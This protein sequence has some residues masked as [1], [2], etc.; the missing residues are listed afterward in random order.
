MKN[1]DKDLHLTKKIL[2]YSFLLLISMSLFF[3]S[4]KDLLEEAPKAVAEEL[5]YNTIEEI[6]SS[7]NAIYPPLSWW[8][9]EQTLI[10]DAHTDWGYGR[11]SRADYNSFQGFNSSNI[12]QA[13]NRWNSYYLG[14]RN[15]NILIK[16]ASEAT[17]LDQNDVKKYIGE[18]KFIRALAYFDLVRNWGSVPLRT[19]D[20]MTEQDIEKSPVETIYDFIITDLLAGEADLPETQV[21]IGRPTKYSAKTLLADVYLTLGNFAEARDKANEVIQSGKYSL[22]PVESKEDFQ[23]NLFGPDIITTP[24][25]IFYFKYKRESDYGNWIL[26]VLNHPST[27][28]FN[29][30]GAFAH[31]S[32]SKLP[33]HQNWEDGDIRKELWDQVDFG[34]GPTTLVSN[35]Y[36]DTEAVERARGAGNDMPIY[37]YAEVLL[38]YAEASSMAANGPTAEGIEALNKVHRRAYGMDPNTPSSI[39]FNISDYD[40]DRFLDLVLKERGYEF[41]FEGKRW[42]DLKRTGKARE[43]I[44]PAKGVTIA[45]KHFLWPIPLSELNY[46]KALDGSD[47]NPGY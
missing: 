24:E 14:I 37:R 30:G 21:H 8:R 20:N 13:G 25:E 39:D 9:V 6:E 3:V 29:F 12:N 4:C 40:K 38:I 46:N 32:D 31:Y 15:A 41:V 42:Y 19:V 2:R 16:N 5:F 36:R 45:E 10:L 28:N 44:E 23:I 18:A 26:F 22:V 17:S 35:K 27:G 1:T 33:F 47:Q 11:G 7:A 43:I 34:S